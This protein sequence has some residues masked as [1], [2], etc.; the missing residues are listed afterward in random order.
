MGVSPL[1][2]NESLALLQN[3]GDR[4]AGRRLTSCHFATFE[5]RQ[6]ATDP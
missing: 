6:R 4:Q 2:D 1:L 5:K 3:D